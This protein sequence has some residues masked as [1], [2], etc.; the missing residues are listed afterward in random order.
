MS[1]KL[2]IKNGGKD[3][4]Q[5]KSDFR[6]DDKMNIVFDKFEYRAIF[7]P[8]P[9][10][11]NSAI[12]ISNKDKSINVTNAPQVCIKLDSSV[13]AGRIIVTVTTNE[14]NEPINLQGKFTT[15]DGKSV[16]LYGR[17]HADKAHGEQRKHVN[18]LNDYLKMYASE[19]ALRP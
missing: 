9:D 6:N 11:D 17:Y 10:W 19:E 13:K 5:K 3:C 12:I 16:T 1:P 7:N 15:K 8:L 18:I 2:I 4:I 14:A